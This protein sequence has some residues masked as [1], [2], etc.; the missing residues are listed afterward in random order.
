MIEDS[1]QS[2]ELSLENVEL[3][4]GKP[5]ITVK[6]LTEDFEPKY[7]LEML[8]KASIGKHYVWRHRHPIDPKH[9]DNHIYGNVS[10]SYVKD[11]LFS[12]IE[13]YTHTDDHKAY[14]ELLK[15][16]FKIGEPLGLS[17]RYRKYYEDEKLEKVIHVDVFEESGT[18]FPKC[19]Q[20]STINL[21]VVNMT[22]EKDE[23]EIEEEKMLEES[24]KKIEELEKILNEKSESLKNYKCK[25]ESLEKELKNKDETLED[26]DSR[27]KKLEDTILEM[28][29]EMEYLS[30]KKPL[31]DKILEVK[32]LDEDE[33][34]FYKSKDAKYLEGKLEKWIKE[35]EKKI[36]TQTLQQSAE[37]ALENEKKEKKKYV[38][39][40]KEYS[41]EEAFERFTTEM[42]GLKLKK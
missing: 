25:L 7:V 30:T 35:S 29:M 42:G 20:C 12:D 2:V 33:L 3:K 10:D 36:V 14:L 17:M 1:I 13:L 18:P 9:T 19:E 38:I 5:V 37:E 31:M 15:E 4:N 40:G 39:D 23:K 32:E 8:S 26:S 34:K 24:K 6:A 27:I 21:G 22:D 41:R 16:R 28:G 11:F